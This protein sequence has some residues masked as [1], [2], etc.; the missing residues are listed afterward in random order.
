MRGSDQ[1]NLCLT[2]VKSLHVWIKESQIRF[3]FVKNETASVKNNLAPIQQNN[4]VTC[5]LMI[6]RV[7]H[8]RH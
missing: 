5:L 4:K 8:S 3:D 1:G 2:T 6:F 7:V